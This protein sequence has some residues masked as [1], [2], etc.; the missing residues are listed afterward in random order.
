MFK[1]PQRCY[2]ATLGV[3]LLHLYELIR[4]R[5]VRMHSVLLVIFCPS[6]A[7]IFN[8]PYPGTTYLQLYSV[9]VQL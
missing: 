4:I 7:C 2:A 9:R 1:F 3:K 5:I 6:C 8:H